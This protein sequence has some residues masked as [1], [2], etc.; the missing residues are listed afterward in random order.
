M[1]SDDPG[2]QRPASAI[3]HSDRDLDLLLLSFEILAQNGV[4]AAIGWSDCRNDLL[5]EACVGIEFVGSGLRDIVGNSQDLIADDED[6]YILELLR[7][8]VE[9]HNILEER[10]SRRVVALRA[11]LRRQPHARRSQ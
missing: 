9:N 5:V 3:N 8:T 6:I 2:H 7:H 11:G 1:P 4:P 10:D